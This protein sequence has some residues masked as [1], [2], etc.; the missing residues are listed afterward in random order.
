[1]FLDNKYTKVYN[2]IIEKSKNRA[3]F[4]Y[5]ENHHI[6]PRCLGGGDNK[7]N[8]AALT[9]REHYIVHV[10]LVKMTS[11]TD[12]HKMLHAF[13]AMDNFISLNRYSSKLYENL[14]K[15]CAV[16]IGRSNKQNKAAHKKIAATRKLREC[17]VGNKNSMFGRSAP[18]ENNLKWYTNGTKDIYVTEGTQ[19]L[20]FLRGRSSVKGN[21]NPLKNKETAMKLSKTRTTL[22]RN[23]LEDGSFTM[24]GRV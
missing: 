5:K 15:E 2:K 24:V 10:L 12:R 14:R 21:K 13:S 4:G 22:Q 9:A 3:I 1:M 8:L 6:V 20:G 7:E 16:N 11:G 17:G 18:K 19:P 23:Y